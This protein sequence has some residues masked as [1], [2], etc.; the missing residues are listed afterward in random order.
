[1]KDYRLYQAL[2]YQQCG[3]TRQPDGPAGHGSCGRSTGRARPSHGLRSSLRSGGLIMESLGA[4]VLYALAG[5]VARLASHLE[6]PV[7]K[8]CND[9][10]FWWVYPEAT[11]PVLLV[12]KAVRATSAL[13]AAWLLA[14]KG[15]A[16]ESAV[17]L[18]VATD[19]ANEIQAMSVTGI[20]GQLDEAQRDFLAQFFGKQPDTIEEFRAMDRSRF[21]KRRRLYDAFQK[22]AE[23]NTFGDQSIKDMSAFL[24]F[25]FDKYVHGSY[26]SAMELYNGRT[27]SFHM[28]GIEEMRPFAKR[29]VLLKTVH[30]LNALSFVAWLF[31]DKTLQAEIIETRTLLD[32]A[33]SE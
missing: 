31:G 28:F 30:A 32:N 3:L 11:L 17:L 23:E 14:S 29:F 33:L 1:M 19:F 4:Q 5:F 7:R 27:R 18:R 24:D 26:R 13:N 10:T 12:V 9:N 22:F 15:I 20:T 8:P 16:T 2:Y 25:K 21:V 6:Q